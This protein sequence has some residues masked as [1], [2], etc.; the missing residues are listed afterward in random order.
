M[1]RFKTALFFIALLLFISPAM[2]QTPVG[3]TA[4]IGVRTFVTSITLP[5]NVV[6]TRTVMELTR[7]PGWLDAPAKWDWE[8]VLDSAGYVRSVNV[9]VT[10]DPNNT[11]QAY[12]KTICCW[13][14]AETSLVVTD[15]SGVEYAYPLHVTAQ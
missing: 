12:G 4:P 7:H 3:I 8:N 11:T 1:V 5:P 10:L 14:Y 15:V 6:R 13:T 2:A 9:Y